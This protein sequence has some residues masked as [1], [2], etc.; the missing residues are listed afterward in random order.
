MPHINSNRRPT[1]ATATV[2]ALALLLACIGLAACG[3]SSKS[4][5]TSANASATTPAGTGSTGTTGPTGPGAAGRG[6]TRFKA[7]R[8]CLQKNGITLPK[9]TPGQRRPGSPGGFL[10]SGGGPQ[11]PKGVTRAQYE[12]AI[13]KCG[14]GAFAGG[15]AARLKSPAYKQALTKFAACMR[16]NGVDLPA[17]NTSGSGPIF[18]TKGLNMSSAQ[19]QAA[20]SKCRTDLIGAFRGG[21]GSSSSSSSGGGGASGASGGPAAQAPAG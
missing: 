16:E 1:L 14:G 7:L 11:L 17:P 20:G 13:R 19:F 6:G 9:R 2:A 8:E 21:G 15:A 5:S 12:A 18:D 10:G 3:G 4:A